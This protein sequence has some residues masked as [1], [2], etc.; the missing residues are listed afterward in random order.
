MRPGS[1]FVSD[2][3]RGCLPKYS[4]TPGEAA[5][6]SQV[7]WTIRCLS[8]SNLLASSIQAPKASAR[9]ESRQSAAFC[10]AGRTLPALLSSWFASTPSSTSA[11]NCASMNSNLLAAIVTRPISVRMSSGNGVGSDMHRK[12]PTG[13]LWR[14][15][16]TG[17]TEDLPEFHV[18]GS[19]VGP[20][21]TR[22]TSSRILDP[23]R[24]APARIP[25]RGC[26]SRPGL[27]R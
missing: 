6:I 18:D 2:W 14:S 5:L 22:G 12:V 23:S 25:S 24:P 7:E 10:A 1:G 3:V 11:A 21:I 4:P 27:G 13:R 20:P 19:A 15:H 9:S 26:F 17:A 8:A 16:L